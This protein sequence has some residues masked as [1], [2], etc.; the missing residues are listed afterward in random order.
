MTRS[1]TALALLLLILT[2]TPCLAWHDATH[3]AVVEAAG[4]HNYAYLAVGA[5]MAKEKAGGHE[6]GNHYRDNLKS[7]VVTP[8]MVLDQVRDYNCR[9]EGEGHLYGAIVA[10]LGQYRDRRSDGKY[11]RYALGFAA[12]Y[13][14]D[15][16]MPLHN[17]EYNLFNRTFHSANDGVVEGSD[18]EPIEAKVSRIARQIGKRMKELP[19][20]Q[21]PAAKDG[22][23]KFNRALAKE[24]AEVANS[25]IALGYAMQEANPQ[26][27]L[28]TEDEAYRRLALSAR[29]LKAAF[30]ALR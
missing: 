30:A 29:L 28:M 2:S 8:D 15:L 7:V 11:D 17:T 23:V 10:A 16:S 22:M 5:D 1:F 14:G 24:I 3:M 13:I 27:P 25:S 9:C 6:E 21:L 26:R 19:P 18:D 4:L 12:H 20:L